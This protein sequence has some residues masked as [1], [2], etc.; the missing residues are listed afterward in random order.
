MRARTR[1]LTHAHD[2]LR[3]VVSNPLAF[4]IDVHI[5]DDH[6]SDDFTGSSPSTIRPAGFFCPLIVLASPF[7]HRYIFGRGIPGCTA[8]APPRGTFC[9]F[10]G[11]LQI[12]HWSH[13][14][15]GVLMQLHLYCNTKFPLE[16]S[17]VGRGQSQGIFG[18]RR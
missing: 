16:P 15:V 11:P 17:R 5:S 8:R 13:R 12:F 2:L 1:S 3:W 6:I 10:S 18:T 9:S 4:R 14:P 7:W